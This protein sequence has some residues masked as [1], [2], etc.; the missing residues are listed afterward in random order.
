MI[1]DI[2]NMY[3]QET[4]CQATYSAD[5]EIINSVEGLTP[6]IAAQAF[7]SEIGCEPSNYGTSTNAYVTFLYN[8]Y[9][10]EVLT[11]I[12][13]Y[14]DNP[15]GQN[16]FINEMI[17]NLE[18][19]CETNANSLM[20]LLLDDPEAAA[21]FESLLTEY[22][23][24]NFMDGEDYIYS[25]M[26][27]MGFDQEEIETYMSPYN[28]GNDVEIWNSSMCA[29]AGFCVLTDISAWYNEYVF[30][31]LGADWF[32]LDTMYALGYIDSD[33]ADTPPVNPNPQGGNIAC[34]VAPYSLLSDAQVQNYAA[35]IEAGMGCSGNW[36]D[37]LESQGVNTSQF[38]PNDNMAIQVA[39]AQIC[40]GTSS[41]SCD[42]PPYASLIS[43][44]VEVLAGLIVNGMGCSGDWT[45]YLQSQGI[46][47][48]DY[49]P[50]DY[51]KINVA[52]AQ[53]CQGS[54]S[55]EPPL[56]P[57]ASELLGKGKVRITYNQEGEID[58]IKIGNLIWD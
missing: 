48:E 26:V 40:M 11:V 44:E 38:C 55:Q 58:A 56:P 14:G 18:F 24:A 16:T 20:Q 23:S 39:L 41:G 17:A 35:Q 37:Y 46:S 34:D 22:I 29:Q 50:N 51:N 1:G 33:A 43:Q 32:L 6:Q 8:N 27:E 21:L 13:D 54:D 2:Q 4:G 15:A 52:I 53:L 19:L 10:Q 28:Y 25:Q 7:Y 47:T 3:I 30:D 5:S 12:N 36:A 42:T 45:Q 57:Q 49:C 31:Y 9:G